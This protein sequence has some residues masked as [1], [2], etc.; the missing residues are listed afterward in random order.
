M[1]LMAFDVD[2]AEWPGRAQVFAC[3]ATYAA[4][5]VYYRYLARIF[6]VRVGRYHLYCTGGAMSGAVATFNFVGVD[7]AVFC[8]PY[9]VPYLYG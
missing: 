2:C 8:N 5:L 9:G 4:F 6:I 7:Y 3:S 1:N